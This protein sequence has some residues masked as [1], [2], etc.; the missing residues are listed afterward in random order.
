VREFLDTYWIS[1]VYQAPPKRGQGHRLLDQDA[2]ICFRFSSTIEV[3]P[4]ARL[5][6]RD[7]STGVAIVRMGT[8]VT[9]VFFTHR[10]VGAPTSTPVTMTS[11]PRPTRTPPSCAPNC[12]P[13]PT[14]IPTGRF[15]ICKQADGPGVDGSF[16]FRFNSK[17]KTVPVGACSLLSSVAEGTLTITENAQA[18]YAVSDIYTIPANRLVS[19]N[20]NDRTVTVTIL[21]GNASTQTVVVFV[22]RAV[23]SQVIEDVLSNS[24][25]TDLRLS[26]NPLDTFLRYVR[27]IERN[28]W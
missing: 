4:G 23:T 10:V 21:P 5:V 13:T 9:E 7:S 12:T 28:R 6:S 2:T 20:I 18:G 11:T 15:Q 8:G 19:K 24:S 25:Q 14:S 26:T 3:R 16:T 22:N 1:K 17:S 27:N